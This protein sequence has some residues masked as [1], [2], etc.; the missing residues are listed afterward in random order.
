MRIKFGIFLALAISASVAAGSA[1]AHHGTASF[2]KTKITILKA[3]VTDFVW[4][5][6][7]GEIDFDVKDAKGN[8]EKWQGSLTSP[9]WLARDGWTRNTLKPGD[10]IV[11]SGNQSKNHQYSLW[12]TKIQLANGQELPVHG[13]ENFQ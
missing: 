13:V 8:I 2:D 4:T 7:H 1:S 11:I 12:I 9:N 6:P 3:T 10:M 5:N